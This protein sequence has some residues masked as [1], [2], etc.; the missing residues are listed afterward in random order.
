MPRFDVVMT[1]RADRSFRTEQVAGMFGLTVAA[2]LRTQFSVVLPEEDEP[3][4]IGLIA[5]PS[6]SGKT[7]VARRA[8]GSRVVEPA[9][10]SKR[11][12]IIDE[13]PAETAVDAARVLTAVGFSSP[14]AW[15]RP[16]ATLSTGEQFRCELARA[17]LR[18]SRSAVGGER[19]IV[20]MDEFTS[21]VDRR[22]ARACAAAVSKAIRQGHV[23]CRLVAVAPHDDVAAWLEADWMLDMA[24]RALRR[25][26]LRRPEIRIDVHACGR[27]AWS[28]FAPHHYLSGDLAPAAECFLALWE[29]RPAAFC[30]TLPLIA[31]RGRR[32][33]TRIATLPDCQGMG[34]GMRVAAAVAEHY[35]ARGIR[36]N[37]TSGHPA[38]VS[39]CR[40]SPWWRAVGVKRYG[41][42]TRRS[43]FPPHRS[44]AGRA[45]ASFEYAGAQRVPAD[46][47]SAADGS[48]DPRGVPQN[49]EPCHGQPTGADF[50]NSVDL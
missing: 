29:G 42:Q 43:A 15:L 3:W 37:L 22:V 9:G 36:V 24:T 44:S 27:E 40:R 19:P 20:V 25:R 49:P 30:A 18:A 34:I 39:H 2:A 28:V 45:V 12:A 1:A 38:V 14:P 21:A 33:F 11:R 31:R 23:G 50:R 16:F 35:R 5:G 6:G 41:S 7:T 13:L 32:R 10:W 26:R 48:A 46:A 4:D 17:L 47:P 8:Y